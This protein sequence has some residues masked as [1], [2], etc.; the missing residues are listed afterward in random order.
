LG[1]AVRVCGIS[2]C[3]KIADFKAVKIR[4]KDGICR[5]LA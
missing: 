3:A 5:W 2:S 1:V 4:N